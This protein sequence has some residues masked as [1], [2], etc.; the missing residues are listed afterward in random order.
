MTTTEFGREGEWLRSALPITREQSPFPWQ[1]RLLHKFQ[2]GYIP[3]HLDIPTGLGK[4]SVM[5][6]WLVARALGAPLPRRLV[7]VVDRR[8]VVDQA[9]EEAERLRGIVEKS[10]DL[11]EAL[12]LES[13]ALPISTLRGQYADNREWLEDPSAPAIVVG[14]V[15]MIGSRMLFSGYGVSRW[16]RPYQAGLLGT[17]ALVALDEAHLVP[18]FERLLQSIADGPFSPGEGQ[19]GVVPAFRIMTLTATGALDA[20]GAFS[21]KADDFN[22]A[23]VR[24]RMEA[25]KGIEI[26]RVPLPDKKSIL[27]TDEMAEHLANA[28]W[29]LCDEGHSSCRVVVFCHQPEVAEKAKKKVEAFLNARAKAEGMK[30]T[31]AKRWATAATEMLVGSRRVYERQDA[32]ARLRKLGFLAARVDQKDEGHNG[33]VFL[34]ATS[35]GEVGVDLDADHMACDLVAWE[36]MVQRLGRVNRRGCGDA[37]V[38]VVC[39]EAQNDQLHEVYKRKSEGESLTVNECRLLTTEN[40]LQAIRSLRQQ[41]GIPPSCS[42]P[43]WSMYDASPTAIRALRE[44]AGRDPKVRE[45]LH[46]AS[47]PPPLHPA[48]TRALV[49]AWS[50]TALKVHPGRPDVLAPWLRGC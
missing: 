22:H 44:R 23:G 10:L 5:A 46:G 16:M 40:R 42:D 47:T 39:A 21:L 20:P 26:R 27:P 33:P 31:E 8:A 7:Y 25:K 50:M 11:R 3:S 28:A 2:G 29:R 36:R 30:Q 45:Q 18:P 35:A 17:D 15:D 43:K 6:I 34:F 37:K 38:V 49:D 41:Q 13:R 1:V 48:L 14:T 32:L 19:N 12:G 9:T 24:Q 4:T